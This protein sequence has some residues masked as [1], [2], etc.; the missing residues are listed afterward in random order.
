MSKN[1]VDAFKTDRPGEDY[2]DKIA[3]WFRFLGKEVSKSETTDYVE[4]V[5]QAVKRPQGYSRNITPRI[6]RTRLNTM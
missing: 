2:G 4:S 3:V 1:R 6:G 5:H